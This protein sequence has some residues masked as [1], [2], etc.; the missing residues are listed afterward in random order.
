MDRICS[1][2]TSKQQHHSRYSTEK[3]VEALKHFY[4]KYTNT[5]LEKIKLSY[6]PNR[7]SDPDQYQHWLALK[8]M[9]VSWKPCPQET[10][11]EVIK[12]FEYI[13][14]LDIISEKHW[15][16]T[17][18]Y[19]ELHVYEINISSFNK[20]FSLLKTKM[21][22]SSTFSIEIKNEFNFND[23]DYSQFNNL[24]SWNN[25]R[26]NANKI[27]LCFDNEVSLGQ[28]PYKK[29][30]HLLKLNLYFPKFSEDERKYLRNIQKE[31]RI[32]FSSNGFSFYYMTDKGKLK[33]KKEKI[34]L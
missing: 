15:Q 11:E 4:D 10:D 13:Q 26:Q 30:H 31:L 29:I 2:S 18:N 17:S 8:D 23:Y 28:Q 9:P 5:K 33:S 14:S 32:K 6:Y 20:L 19:S 12:N 3:F 25:D 21:N 27:W 1:Y 16:K 24:F 34:K 22:T 7:L